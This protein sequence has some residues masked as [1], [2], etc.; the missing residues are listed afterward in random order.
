M[1]TAVPTTASAPPKKTR[2]VSD[3][4]RTGW[5]ASRK[6]TL[7]TWMVKHGKAGDFSGVSW[8]CHFLVLA[9]GRLRLSSGVRSAAGSLEVRLKDLLMAS[10]AAAITYI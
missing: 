4:P 7:G 8:R 10:C 3:W 2:K 1:T 6:A 5:A 9:A